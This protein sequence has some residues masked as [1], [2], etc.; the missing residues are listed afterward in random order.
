[1][2]CFLRGQPFN[3]TLRRRLLESVNNISDNVVP[4]DNTTLSGYIVYEN[5]QMLLVLAVV[6]FG[7]T[8]ARRRRELTGRE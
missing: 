6:E 8:S 5:Q 4:M 2:N 1:M 3:L 7:D